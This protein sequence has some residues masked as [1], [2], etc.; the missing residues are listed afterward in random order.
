MWY[1]PRH[2]REIPLLSGISGGRTN[3]YYGTEL[4]KVVVRRPDK[5]TPL[6]LV[7]NDFDR[8]ADEICLALQT[9]LAHRTVLQI[10]KANPEDQTVFGAR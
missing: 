3:D 8:T 4:R 7:T 1:L 5:S 2:S 6:V 9:A 10:V